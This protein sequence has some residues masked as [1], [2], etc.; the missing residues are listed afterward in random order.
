M[1]MCS[2]LCKLHSDDC[3]QTEHTEHFVHVFYGGP[4][5]GGGGVGGGG[6]EAIRLLF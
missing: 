6:A 1:T 5:G 3:V 2:S 4:G